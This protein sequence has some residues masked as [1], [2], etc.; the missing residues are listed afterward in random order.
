MIKHVLALGRESD[1]QDYVAWCGER[2]IRV[3]CLQPPALLLD[4]VA[5]WDARMQAVYEAAGLEAAPDHVVSFHDGFQVQVDVLKRV[6]GL[7]HRRPEALFTLTDKAAFKAVPAT[8]SYVSRY[9]RLPQTVSAEDGWASVGKSLS[10]PLVVKPSNAFYS[11]GVVRVD[12]RAQWDKALTQ[13]RRVCRMIGAQ[14]GGSEIL[15]EEYIDGEEFSVDG[16]VLD[17]VVIP[18]LLHHKHPRLVGPTFHENAQVSCP[19]DLARGADF[20]AALRQII[21]AI[22]LDQSPFHAEFRRTDAGQLYILELAPR[23]S[24][25]GISSRYLMDICL[26]LD[27]HDVEF[28]LHRPGLELALPRRQVGL[29]YDFS[30]RRNGVLRNIEKTVAQCREAG[31]SVVIQHRDNGEFVMAPPVNFETIL[32][33]FFPCDNE[34]EAMRIFALMEACTVETEAA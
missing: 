1:L 2:G 8:A 26:G 15:V 9:I 5:Q 27:V 24:G 18:L 16:Y 6:L 10:L 32:T 4:D 25:G 34:A 22:G 33:A 11:A 29:E 12:E 21:G 28:H 20:Q 17:G 31:A 19:F 30:V 23:I 14:R 3:T 7:P 13:A